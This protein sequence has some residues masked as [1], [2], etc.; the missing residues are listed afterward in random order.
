MACLS[1]ASYI[2]RSASV[3]A[4]EFMDVPAS[5]PPHAVILIVERD[6]HTRALEEYFLS[7]AGFA[8]EMTEDG[9]M[10][11]DRARALKPHIVVC[12]LLVPKLDGLS[13]CR[14]I[15]RSES[16]E[17]TKI[18]IFSFLAAQDRALEAGADAFLL[19]PLSDRALIQ[20]IRELLNGLPQRDTGVKEAPR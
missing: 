19:K 20:T 1:G 6:P 13:L 4:G 5:S 2:E 18:L 14:A 12:E 15:R 16:L 17:H 8:V 3:R 7:E 10:A 9:E 11:L